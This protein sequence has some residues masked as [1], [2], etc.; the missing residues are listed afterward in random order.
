[1]RNGSLAVVTFGIVLLLAI[2]SWGGETVL[3][4]D[5][6]LIARAAGVV[7]ADGKTFDDRRTEWLAR[8]GKT[9]TGLCFL[10][11]TCGCYSCCGRD[12]SDCGNECRFWIGDGD[13]GC[14]L[15]TDFVLGRILEP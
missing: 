7:G 2:L 15:R 10:L 12:I 6:V 11:R 3:R 9:L 8:E 14:G 4:R 13:C 1:M 5:F